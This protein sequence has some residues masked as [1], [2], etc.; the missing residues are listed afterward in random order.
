MTTTLYLDDS[1]VGIWL[2]VK[3]DV[4][5]HGAVSHRR[6]HHRDRLPLV[7]VY[8]GRGRGYRGCAIIVRRNSAERSVIV[9]CGQNEAE[10][11][12]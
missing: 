1:A 4:I 12:L 6:H 8:E 10:F 7:H 9:D 3:Y 11:V 2:I 5:A